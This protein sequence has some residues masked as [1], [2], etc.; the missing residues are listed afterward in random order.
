M[1]LLQVYLFRLVASP[2]QKGNRI[3]WFG[4]MQRADDVKPAKYIVSTVNEVGEDQEGKGRITSR[5][6]CSK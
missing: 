5:E 6:T 1:D 2:R 3:R 4:H